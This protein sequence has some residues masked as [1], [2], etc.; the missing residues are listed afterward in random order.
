MI[1]MEECRECC[2]QRFKSVAAK[3][4]TCPECF[5]NGMAPYF[6]DDYEADRFIDY[7][8]ALRESIL[9]DCERMIREGGAK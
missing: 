2:G 8:Q 5:G 9:K 6:S 1:S 3:P 4:V 7:V